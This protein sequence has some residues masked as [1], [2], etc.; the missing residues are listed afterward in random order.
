VRQEYQSAVVMAR[1]Q[2]LPPPDELTTDVFA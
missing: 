1:Q 2:P